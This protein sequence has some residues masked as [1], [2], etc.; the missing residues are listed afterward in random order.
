MH[1]IVAMKQVLDL[2]MIKEKHNSSENMTSTM[3]I[4]KEY[5]SLFTIPCTIVVYQSRKTLCNLGVSINLM[6]FAMFR[7]IGLGDP[8]PTIMRL[9][10]VDH[11]IKIPVGV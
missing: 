4:K 1:N 6:S 2:I 10:I 3:V 5:P 9:I 7:N 11:L 8:K